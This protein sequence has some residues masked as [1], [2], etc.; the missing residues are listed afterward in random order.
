MEENAF[1]AT[2]TKPNF[3]AHS[4]DFNS[5]YPNET[6]LIIVNRENKGL[7]SNCSKKFR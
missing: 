3:L 6:E 2:S 5:P 1:K 7:I 4:F